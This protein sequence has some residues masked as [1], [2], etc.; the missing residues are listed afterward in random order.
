M[1]NFD[2]IS[3]PPGN[4]QVKLRKTDAFAEFSGVSESYLDQQVQAKVA[5][6]QEATRSGLRLWILSFNGCIACFFGLIALFHIAALG[7]VYWMFNEAE[8]LNIEHAGILVAVLLISLTGTLL[9]GFWFL[10]KAR[11]ENTALPNLGEQ[12]PERP[13]NL[14]IDHSRITFS[15]DRSGSDHDPLVCKLADVQRVS[16]TPEGY[17]LAHLEKGGAGT[18][19]E[20][21]LSGRLEKEDA[22]WMHKSVS[23]LLGLG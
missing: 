1:I 2:G 21:V 7:L 3:D 15:E 14:R 22:M 6:I 12:F 9:F 13:W 5:D 4:G 23:K 17:V 16:L 18:R 8:E 10:F 19:E 11:H 20:R